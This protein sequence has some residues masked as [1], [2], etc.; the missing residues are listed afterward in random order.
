MLQKEFITEDEHKVINS[1]KIDK[2]FNSHIGKTILSEKN[3]LREYSIMSY[4]PAKEIIEDCK[5]DDRI[6]I[7]GIADCVIKTDSGA[8]IVDYKTDFVKNSSELVD[9]YSTQLELYK[10]AIEQCLSMPVIEMIIYSFCL[11][12]EIKL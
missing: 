12:K 1:S 10:I 8:I 2:F 4:I 6:L 3:V 11:D 5:G 9:K 7:Q